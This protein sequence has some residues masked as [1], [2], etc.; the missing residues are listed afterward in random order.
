MWLTKT[1]RLLYEDK[2]LLFICQCCVIDRTSSDTRTCFVKGGSGFVKAIYIQLLMP[3]PCVFLQHYS[4]IK[5]AHCKCNILA[6]KS[7]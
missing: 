7:V 3:I 1:K 6:K 5:L 4:H 2:M